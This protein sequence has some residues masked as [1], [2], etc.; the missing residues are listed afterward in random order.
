[1]FLQGHGDEMREVCVLVFRYTSVA[2]E[3]HKGQDQVQGRH[4]GHASPEEGYQVQG[5]KHTPPGQFWSASP[6]TLPLAT[7]LVGTQG[8]CQ[9]Q[10]MP[11]SKLLLAAVQ[12]RRTFG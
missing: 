3:H 2:P 5:L 7:A 8:A 9:L 11:H 1:M 4:E 12:L 10:Y 6:L